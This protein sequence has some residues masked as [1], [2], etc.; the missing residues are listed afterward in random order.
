MRV[1]ENQDKHRLRNGI[2]LVITLAAL[3]GCVQVPERVAYELTPASDAD[4]NHYALRQPGEALP[5]AQTNPP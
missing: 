4:R 5:N 2:G 3:Q 1:N